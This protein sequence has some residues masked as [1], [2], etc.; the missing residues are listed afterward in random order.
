MSELNQLAKKV[1]ECCAGVEELRKS[2]KSLSKNAVRQS[3]YFE[4]VIG[5]VHHTLLAHANRIEALEK[6]RDF[7]VDH[8]SALERGQKRGVLEWVREYTAG[9]GKAEPATPNPLAEAMVQQQ[10]R[11][12]PEPR[13]PRE[14]R[15]LTR[16]G[17]LMEAMSNQDGDLFREILPGEANLIADQRAAIERLD[18]ENQRLHEAV[19]D[20]HMEV[21]RLTA[22]LEAETRMSKLLTRRLAIAV[23]WL[24]LADRFGDMREW[25]A[26]HGITLPSIDAVF[27]TFRLCARRCLEMIEEA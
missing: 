26:R 6:D 8:I 5:G 13:K 25:G 17:W 3:E 27:V 12:A 23:E 20:E 18:A 15:L 9:V 10:E 14:V 7:A 2:S 19:A 1:I 11:Q 24:R 16:D 21:E 4:N 22:D